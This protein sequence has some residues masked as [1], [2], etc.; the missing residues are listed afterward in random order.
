M[1]NRI[2]ANGARCNSNAADTASEAR[3][4]AA[5]KLS[6]S[7]CSTGRTPPWAATTS[8]T[9]WL[10]RAIAAVIT[11]AWVS[12]SRVEPSTSANSNVTVPVGNSPLTPSSL[13]STNGAST[14]GSISLMLASMR[15]P[16]TAK[17]QHKRVDRGPRRRNLRPCSP[18]STSY[19]GWFETH[20]GR[21]STQPRSEEIHHDNQHLPDRLGSGPAVDCLR[22]PERSRRGAPRH[23]AGTP[24]GGDRDRTTRAGDL[25][26]RTGPRRAARL[27]L[28][29]CGEAGDGRTGH[30]VRPGVGQSEP[31]HPGARRRDAPPAAPTCVEGLYPTRRRAATDAHR[32]RHD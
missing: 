9:T 21:R 26:P 29:P 25:E 22:P 8:H 12:H 17:H 27:P 18:K 20:D 4:N 5:T 32:R 28:R 11:S 6:P 15:P 10:K 3:A 1:R 13:Q 23:P 2:G 31:E 7:P 16:R 14:R 30:H 19:G 24:A